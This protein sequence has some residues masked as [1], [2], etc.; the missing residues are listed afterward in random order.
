MTDEAP[1]KAPSS[2][3]VILLLLRLLS[4]NRHVRRVSLMLAAEKER[5]RLHFLQLGKALKGSAGLQGGDV[6]VVEAAAE[7]KLKCS[8]TVTQVAFRTTVVRQAPVFLQF[9]GG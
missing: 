8:L 5:F 7:N 3:S 1:S 2:I 9:I 6:I 4:G